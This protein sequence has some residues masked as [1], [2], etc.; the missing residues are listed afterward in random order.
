M[1]RLLLWL[2]TIDHQLLRKEG[3]YSIDGNRIMH[4]NAPSFVACHPT[5]K[6]LKV[7][8]PDRAGGPCPSFVLQPLPERPSV[9]CPSGILRRNTT[10]S[11]WNKSQWLKCH[12]CTALQNNLSANVIWQDRNSLKVILS[13]ISAFLKFVNILRFLFVFLRRNLPAASLLV[14]RASCTCYCQ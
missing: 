12:G 9:P 11:R 5:N 3:S 1:R 2:C 4:L 7:E 6:L 13:N 10:N 14:A 8:E